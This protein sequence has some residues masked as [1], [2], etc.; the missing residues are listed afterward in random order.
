M[1]RRSYRGREK[2]VQMVLQSNSTSY[3]IDIDE[4]LALSNQAELRVPDLTYPR[5]LE[6][7]ANAESSSFASY[8][9]F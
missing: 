4:V 3:L 5:E 9:K 6:I 8:M 1:R 2:Q 7:K